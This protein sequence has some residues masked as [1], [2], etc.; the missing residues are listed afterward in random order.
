MNET[1]R[2]GQILR[3]IRRDKMWTLQKVCEE[4]DF[5]IDAPRLSRIEGSDSVPNVL[6]AYKIA[7]SL[8]VSLDEVCAEYFGVPMKPKGKDHEIPVLSWVQAGALCSS[9]T[10]IDFDSCDKWLKAPKNGLNPRS[11]AL[12]VRGESMMTTQGMSF[13]DGCYIIVDPDKPAEHGSF[14]IAM[15]RDTEESTFKKLVKDG[16]QC[17][18]MPLNPRYPVIPAT[19]EMVICGVVTSMVADLE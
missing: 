14:V 5:V 11:Y 2:F 8:G 15:T 13:P 19:D 12:Q 17:L 16:G 6:A 4:A 10:D 7:K 1:I 3:R 9:P 18:L